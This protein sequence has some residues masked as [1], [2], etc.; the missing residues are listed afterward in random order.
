MSN[1]SKKFFKI[2]KIFFANH[3]NLAIKCKKCVHAINPAKSH[4]NP[5]TVYNERDLEIFKKQQIIQK[6]SEKSD[7]LLPT[8]HFIDIKVSKGV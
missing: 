6:S 7:I 8:G 4:S 2:Y 3:H 5:R 1:R